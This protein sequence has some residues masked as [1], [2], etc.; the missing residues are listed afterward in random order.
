MRVAAS[1]KAGR[2]SSVLSAMRRAVLQVLAKWP[3]LTPAG[4]EVIRAVERRLEEYVGGHAVAVSSGTVAIEV[5]LRALGI[6]S[7]D[8][9]VV[10]P[11]DWGATTGAVLRCGAKPVF[12][13][14]D[15]RTATMAPASLAARIGPRTKAVVVTHWA[16]C[17]ADLD[18]V[19]ELARRHR[20]FVLED[21]AQALGATYRDRPVGSFGDAAVFS[22]GWGKLVCAGEGGALVFRREELWRKAVGLSQHPLRQFRE[23]A[24]GLGDLAMNARMHPLAAALVLAQWDRWPGWL[25]RRR[26]ACLY[27]SSQLRGWRGVAVPFDPP[28]GQ[29]SFHRYVLRFDR[30]SVALHVLELLSKQGWAAAAAFPQQPLHHRL[31]P[32]GRRDRCPEAERA[33]Q[34]S[35]V[36]DLDWCKVSRAELEDLAQVLQQG[37]S[38]CQ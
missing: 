5:G 2:A 6:G 8:E 32:R 30:T 31:R 35:I 22:F 33:C 38:R 37:V 21:C 16:G 17:P 11:Y 34:G 27:L 9:V 4:G 36:L 12:A 24:W 26:R 15:P 7:G 13:D 23:G 28:H 14:I 3:E 10:S 29:H 20:L 1:G 25:E 19:L 18:G